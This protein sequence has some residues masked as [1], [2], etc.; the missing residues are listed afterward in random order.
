MALCLVVALGLYLNLSTLEWGLITF[1]IGLVL[2]AELFNTAV[3]RVGDEVAG[4]KYSQMVRTA[5]DASAAAV[6]LSALTALA[7]GTLILF[8]PLVQR[9]ISTFPSLSPI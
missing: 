6:L 5:K 2:V 1:S 3:E 9:L 8:I 4:G 7:I